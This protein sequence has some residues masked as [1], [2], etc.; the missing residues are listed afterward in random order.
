[1]IA[2]YERDFAQRWNLV[3]YHDGLPPKSVNGQQKERFGAFPVPEDCIDVV[4]KDH[5][6]RLGKIKELFPP[7]Q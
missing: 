7:P 2:V 5:C 4:G 3:V 1:M 6:P